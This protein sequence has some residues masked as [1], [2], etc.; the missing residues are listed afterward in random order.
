M[1][2]QQENAALLRGSLSPTDN[3]NIENGNSKF[4]INR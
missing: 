4:I 1:R 3:E 2:E